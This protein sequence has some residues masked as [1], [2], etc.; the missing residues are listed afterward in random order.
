MSRTWQNTLSIPRREQASR[1]GRLSARRRATRFLLRLLPRPSSRDERRRLSARR[2]E[3]ASPPNRVERT[4]AHLKAV[5]PDHYFDITVASRLSRIRRSHDVPVPAACRRMRFSNST[6]PPIRHRRADEHCPPRSRT[7]AS[8]LPRS[9]K[10]CRDLTRI[11]GGIRFI[12]WHAKASRTS[13]ITSLL[14]SR[15]G[16]HG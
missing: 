2:C 11:R 13:P 10:Q 9:R 1:R 15:L 3:S 6:A 4:P 14:P 5:Y 12:T 16:R 8:Q 7:S